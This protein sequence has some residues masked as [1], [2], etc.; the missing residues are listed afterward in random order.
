M[1][2]QG[3]ES[4]QGTPMHKRWKLLA[5]SDWFHQKCHVTSLTTGIHAKNEWIIRYKEMTIKLSKRILFKIFD[6]VWAANVLSC[7]I[8]CSMFVIKAGKAESI[9]DLKSNIENLHAIKGAYLNVMHIM[10][11]NQPS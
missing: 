6:K 5:H 2:L 3:L 7:F 1:Y 9:V 10:H 4:F 11:L 8:F